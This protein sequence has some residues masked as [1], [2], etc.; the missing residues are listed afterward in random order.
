M[1]KKDLVVKKNNLKQYSFQKNILV[2]KLFIENSKIS[3]KNSLEFKKQN[4]IDNRK[5]NLIKKLLKNNI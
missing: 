4:L 1:F 2:N 5:K 3:I